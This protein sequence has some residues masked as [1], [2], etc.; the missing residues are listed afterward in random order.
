MPLSRKINEME[1]RKIP[2]VKLGLDKC[3]YYLESTVPEI[4]IGVGT[5]GPQGSWIFSWLA[6]V[7]SGLIKEGKE[8]VTVNYFPWKGL[9][10]PLGMGP[11]KP[12]LPT[13]NPSP[14]SRENLQRKRSIW[15]KCN[16]WSLS[17]AFPHFIFIPAVTQGHLS[18]RTW[19]PQMCSKKQWS[20][21]MYHSVKEN[22][23]VVRWGGD[24]ASYTPHEICNLHRPTRGADKAL[25]FIWSP[26]HLFI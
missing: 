3:C 8:K 20:W 9:A 5:F 11:S 22:S 21:K 19:L 26:I 13:C 7:P 10:K 23:Y 1:W 15:P 2:D 14:R 6:G 17:L 18:F 4:S 16:P 24:S 12:S 25:P